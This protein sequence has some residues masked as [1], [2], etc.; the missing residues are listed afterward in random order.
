M[1]L[2]KNLLTGKIPDKIDEKG[3]KVPRKDFDPKFV[4]R[5][6][7]ASAM[8]MQI[9]ETY[10]RKWEMYK[11]VRGV[12][13]ADEVGGGKTF[14]ALAII[15]K[16][17]INRAKKGNKRFRVLIV[18]AP[19]IQSKWQWRENLNDS[20]CD[21][22]KFVV[23]SQI[24]E[25]NLLT[26]LFDKTTED[27]I[28]RS[29]KRWK[30]KCSHMPRQGIWLT[31]FGALPMTRYKGRK[32]IFRKDKDNFIPYNS[33][34]F[35]IV[36]EAHAVKSGYKDQD[37]VSNDAFNDTA[38]RKIHALMKSQEKIKP[39]LLL[40]TATPFQNHIKEFIHLISLTENCINDEIGI[41]KIIEWGLSEF[42]RQ[43]FLLKSELRGEGVDQ[44]WINRLTKALNHEISEMLNEKHAAEISKLRR[45]HELQINK[46]RNG[47][48]DY[49]RDL[50]IRNTRERLDNEPIKICLKDPK[51]RLEYLLLR[52]LVPPEKDE[53]RKMMFSTSLSQLVSSENSFKG[54]LTQSKK[55]KLDKINAIF[56]GEH[57]FF[58]AKLDHLINLIESR[59]YNKKRVVTVFCR[60]IPT[61]E[62]L[63]NEIL[64]LGYDC[65]VMQGSTPSDKRIDVLKNL[66]SKNDKNGKRPIVFIVS[67]VGNEGLDFD[68]FSNT[69]IHYD[70]NYNPAVMDQRNGRVYR[71][72]NLTNPK[73]GNKQIKHG[74]D[75][76]N[77]VGIRQLILDETYDQQIKYI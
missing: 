54:R 46:N 50:V 1:A 55:S 71:G 12:L 39:K 40:L 70:G 3:K 42:D 58:H 35:I 33:F 13:L 68:A 21:L 8:A 4:N 52:D 7:L 43:I 14:E 57:S 66:K 48:D 16:E 19:A 75:E 10:P 53:K 2:L 47:L 41:S 24:K 63:K 28:I 30:E 77:T 34:D 38:I 9:M 65:E 23:Q 25:K 27:R 45:P 32:S 49:I 59:K 73:T 51:A 26:Q 72:D 62:F 67:Q 31:S 44:N 60:F 61:L 15:A 11:N 69:V 29:K 5:Q 20:P 56:N 74:W 6:V 17:F 37:E 64:K 36:D 22:E 18:A 76:S